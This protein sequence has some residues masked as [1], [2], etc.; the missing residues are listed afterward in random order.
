MMEAIITIS[1][2]FAGVALGWLLS[3]NRMQTLESSLR[4]RE[5]KLGLAAAHEAELSARLETE[6]VSASEKWDSLERQLNNLRTT[7]SLL[8][9]Q[10][11]AAS[12]RLNSDKLAAQERQRSLEAQICG[13]DAELRELRE[14]TNNLSVQKAELEER[15][16]LFNG[17][18]SSDVEAGARGDFEQSRQ[19]ISELI[20]PVYT[21]LEKVDER[22]QQLEKAREG[23]YS[24]LREQVRSLGEGQTKLQTETGK[25]ITAL[26]APIARGRSGEIQ[27]QRAVEM[28]GMLEHCDFV[29]QP[30]GDGEDGRLRPDLL[31][32]L[33]G[34]KSI[35]VDAKAPLTAYLEALDAADEDARRDGMKAHAS[36]V[37]TH[38]QALG[39][40]A[41]ADQFQ[42]A[43][44]FVVLFLPG[45]SFFSA[46]LENDPDLIQ[47]GIAQN[48]M[49]ATPT[50]LVALLR[51]AAFGWRQESLAQNAAEISALGKD[52]YQRIWALVGHWNKL[53]ASLKNAVSAYNIATSSFESRV[54][55]SARRFEDLKIAP[56][57][58]EI[59]PALPVDRNVRMLLEAVGAD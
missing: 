41:Y 37:R 45:E 52:L 51:T 27:L 7:V 13:Q 49:L 26:H 55:A 59:S 48:V 28:A 38:L 54:L 33:P 34:G 24:D 42:P 9:A 47:F 18:K 15:L 22:I 12:A 36:Q 50:T 21:S 3:N 2:F 6:R 8:T 10:E 14:K 58:M 1:C 39:Q 30:A 31:V 32:H 46:A 23:A 4:D 11:A 5:E 43:P 44:D 40:Q 53:G 56:A 16:R 35:V 57:G 20:S 29:T 25:L 17:A 19:A